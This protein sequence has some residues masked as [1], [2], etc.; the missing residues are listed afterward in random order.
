MS[1][2]RRILIVEDSPT[3]RNFLAFALERLRNVDIV[4]AGD[5]MDA[6]RAVTQD[7]S[8]TSTPDGLFSTDATAS[9]YSFARK[10]V[11]VQGDPDTLHMIWH[12]KEQGPNYRIRYANSTD[13]GATWNLMPDAYSSANE[14]YHPALAT[15]GEYLFA[16]IQ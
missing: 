16:A 11:R 9:G 2:R 13:N 7:Y 14:T 15:D 3:V 8:E 4:E 10:L 1:S 5:G 6:L 12:T